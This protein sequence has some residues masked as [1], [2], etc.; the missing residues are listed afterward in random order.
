M[1]I[2]ENRRAKFEYA[3]F[4]TLECGIVLLGTEVKSLRDRHVNFAD[5]YA[6]LKNQEVFLIGLKIEPYQ[7]G[8]HVNHETDR[9]RKLLLN[10][11]EIEKLAKETDRKGRTL[12][13]L[14]LYFK[15]GKAKVLV[16]VAEGKTKSDKRDTIQQ[17]EGDREIARVMRR[18]QR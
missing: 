5:S 13:P 17:R 3:I 8:T 7:Y 11:S 15:E 18:G 4:E 10:R 9:T 1:I 14:K 2:A 12:V 16:G 6:L